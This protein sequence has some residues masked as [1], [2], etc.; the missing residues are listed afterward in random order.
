MTELRKTIERTSDLRRRDDLVSRGVMLGLPLAL[1]P[2]LQAGQLFSQ[3]AASRLPH[4]AVA[5]L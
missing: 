4:L 5:I 3:S 1:C 2:L